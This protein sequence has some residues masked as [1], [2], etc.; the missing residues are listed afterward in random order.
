MG[1]FSCPT[2]RG[3]ISLNGSIQC[4]CL[5]LFLRQTAI[6]RNGCYRH[7]SDSCNGGVYAKQQSRRQ[8]RALHYATKTLVTP[9]SL[10]R[11][12]CLFHCWK[13][14]TGVFLPVFT[15]YSLL[16]FLALSF[17]VALSLSLSF[18]PFIPLVMFL[19]FSHSLL[20]SLYLSLSL[21]PFPFQHQLIPPFPSTTPQ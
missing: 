8:T 17:S 10:I 5:S 6:R 14:D 20:L 12:L 11:G 2:I 16:I 3:K 1:H 15:P 4:H 18:S 19:R 7:P 9:T 21:S 13:E